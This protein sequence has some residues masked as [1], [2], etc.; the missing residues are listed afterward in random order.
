M[1][2]WLG[3]FLQ[4]GTDKAGDRWN[5]PGKAL[6]EGMLVADSHNNVAIKSG[7]RG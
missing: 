2:A 5:S 4:A 3:R 6:S 1:S 7:L